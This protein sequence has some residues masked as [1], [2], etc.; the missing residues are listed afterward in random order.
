[1]V[2]LEGRG[3][4]PSALDLGADFHF[5]PFEDT[6]SAQFIPN[7]LFSHEPKARASAPA[8]VD[9]SREQVAER[10]TSDE[11]NVMCHLTRN[12]AHIGG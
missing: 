7:I 6:G 2:D 8:K 1:M 12:P 3:F 10:A 5:P 11:T 4:L 9:E